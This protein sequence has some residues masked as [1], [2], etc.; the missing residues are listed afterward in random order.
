MLDIETAVAG[1]MATLEEAE[2]TPARQPEPPKLPV[3]S[4]RY[5]RLYPP[6]K[7]AFTASFETACSA[8][9][10]RGLA[11]RVVTEPNQYIRPTYR[12]HHWG[13]D[14]DALLLVAMILHARRTITVRG[15]VFP[16]Y[17][18]L[19]AVRTERT[20]PYVMLLALAD[21]EEADHAIWPLWCPHATNKFDRS[22]VDEW[23]GKAI[24][25]QLSPRWH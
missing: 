9:V 6:I 25:E 4:A 12:I 13:A 16:V 18:A 1:F 11:A 20:K 24:Y 10:A 14:L 7:A 5:D 23:V 3:L 19:V 2:Q 15:K 17:S 8:L 22:V 21:A